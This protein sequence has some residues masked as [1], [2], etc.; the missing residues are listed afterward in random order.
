MEIPPHFLSCLVLFVVTPLMT[1][2]DDQIK[3]CGNFG[4]TT[5][6]LEECDDAWIDVVLSSPNT[7]EVNYDVLLEI[8]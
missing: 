2:V 4:A 1:L 3:S 7:L 8:A 5:C 6:K